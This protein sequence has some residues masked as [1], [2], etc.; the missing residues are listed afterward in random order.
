METIDVLPLM[1]SIKCLLEHWVTLYG[2]SYSCC[3]GVFTASC[4]TK[5]WVKD[6]DLYS[7]TVLSA[8]GIS[9]LVAEVAA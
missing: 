4:L 3:N 9:P 1:S 7:H 8:D 5:T 2:P 6:Q